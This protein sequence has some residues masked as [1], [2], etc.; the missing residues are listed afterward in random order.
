MTLKKFGIDQL[1]SFVILDKQ[2]NISGTAF[3]VDRVETLVDTVTGQ[4]YFSGGLCTGT[5][6]VNAG[7]NSDQ[8]RITKAIPGATAA[9]KNS[10]IGLYI[11]DDWA[12]TK[13]FELNIGVRYDYETNMLNDS[14]VT[15]ADR[16]AALKALDGPR[17]GITPPAGQTQ[18]MTPQLLPQ[19]GTVHAEKL[20]GGGARALLTCFSVLR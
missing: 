20:S 9:F 1:P 6:V 17:W 16:V 11:Q 14:Y 13:Q 10:Q 3:G 8:C 4:P 12:V 2:G 18:S 7:L 19:G 15:P 5:N